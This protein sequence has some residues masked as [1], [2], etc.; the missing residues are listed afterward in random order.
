MKIAPFLACLACVPILMTPAAAQTVV[1]SPVTLNL[2][3]EPLDNKM[4]GGVQFYKYGIYAS[5]G[6]ST[7]PQ[8]Y[9]FDT[10]APGFYAVYS[11]NP[12]YDSTAWGTVTNLISTNGNMSYVSS[13]NY[14]GNV[15]GTSVTLYSADGASSYRHDAVISTGALDSTNIAVGQ[16]LSISNSQSGK[17]TWPSNGPPPVDSHFYGDF[18]AGLAYTNSGVM[19]VLGQLNYSNGV[20]PGFILALGASGSMHPTLQIGLSSNTLAQYPYQ[21]KINGLNTTNT[22]PVASGATNVIPTYGTGVIQGVYSY[23]DGSN[24]PF[25]TN[26]ALVLDTGATGFQRNDTNADPNPLLPFLSNAPAGSSIADG[27]TFTLNLTSAI[28][29][30]LGMNLFPD[31]SA[32]VGTNTGNISFGVLGGTN[33]AINIGQDLFHEYNVAYDLQNGIVAFQPIALPEPST[34]ALVGLGIAA[35]LAA[36][37]RRL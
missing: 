15:V 26:G 22:F 20:I 36:A 19:N 4:V 13:N 9:E 35:L 10:G 23:S 3:P 34:C 28:S 16:V 37:R 7:N 6:G 17:V 27:V 31:Y 2:Q 5:L 32:L 21:F 25:V 14:Y 8:L 29:M 12:A 30:G 24:P 1:T 33:Y 11:T 18:G